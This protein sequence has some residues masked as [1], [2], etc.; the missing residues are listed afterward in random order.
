VGSLE[1]S[2][3]P[4]RYYLDGDGVRGLTLKASDKG[5]CADV[6]KTTRAGHK[7]TAGDERIRTPPRN[8]RAQLL[9]YIAYLLS[10]SLLGRPRSPLQ[11]L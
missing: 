11:H 9:A 4:S 3:P 6:E 7:K 5:R 10:R 2:A 1:N 8:I